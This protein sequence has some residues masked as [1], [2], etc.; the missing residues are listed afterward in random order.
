[1]SA[2]DPPA[3]FAVLDRLL[4]ARRSCRGFLPDQ[5]DATTIERL[6]AA[7]QRTP[8]WCNTQPWQVEVT[9]GDATER[10]RTAF[11]S[12]PGGPDID[13][14]PGYEGVYQERRREVGWQLYEAVGVAKGD[15]EASAREMLRNFTFFDAPHVAIVHAPRS[16]GVYGAIDCGLYVQSF[17]LAAEALGL[18]ACAQAAVASHGPLLHDH[19]GLGADRQ[20][21]CGIA[22]GHADP[23]H[24]SAGFTS[25]RAS[26]DEATTIH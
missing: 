6:L 25:R 8:S 14:P 9:T 16:L 11:A 7:A 19:F 2:S 4:T 3:D 23:D 20:I 22:F 12:P 13:F 1:M 24:P 17:L 18:G 26:V 10:L 15:R 21:V 5:V